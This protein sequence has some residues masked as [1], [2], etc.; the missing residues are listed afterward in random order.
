MNC[1]TEKADTRRNILKSIG[2]GAVTSTLAIGA[3]SGKKTKK[4]SS[5][6]QS[7]FGNPGKNSN[8]DQ[9]SGSPKNG[10]IPTER[11]N[12]FMERWIDAGFD[13][14]IIRMIQ[15]DDTGAALTD[16]S[17]DPKVKEA[18]VYNQNIDKPSEP[19]KMAWNDESFIKDDTFSGTTIV[20][21]DFFMEAWETD[22]MDGQ[23][24]EYWLL[25]FAATLTP[26]D[27]I[28]WTGNLEDAWLE[29]S[30]DKK[31][32][33]PDDPADEGSEMKKPAPNGTVDYNGATVTLDAT[34]TVEAGNSNAGAQLGLGISTDVEVGGGKLRPHRSRHEPE[35]GVA[36]IHFHGH[37]EDV[38][39][40]A[41]GVEVVSDVGDIKSWDWKTHVKGDRYNKNPF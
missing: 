37:T 19:A 16:K 35:D 11:R 22:L 30:L 29:Y 41:G 20:E 32:E 1:M 25:W 4:Q 8:V 5:G 15:T 23:G 18:K 13:I 6:E 24:G 40:I 39:G 12:E 10:T 14:P 33:G 3:A 7:S 34:G 36:C 26:K 31:D 28:L 21:G 17:G 27:H 9:G 38:I 2:A